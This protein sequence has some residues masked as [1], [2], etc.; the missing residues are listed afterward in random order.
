ME[1][2]VVEAVGRQVEPGVVAGVDP[3]DRPEAFRGRVGQVGR[4]GQ[5]ARPEGGG[6]DDLGVEGTFGRPG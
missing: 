4:I 5:P 6:S 1:D 3:L 2:D